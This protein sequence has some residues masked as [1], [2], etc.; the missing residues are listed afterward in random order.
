MEQ[1]FD[2]DSKDRSIATVELRWLRL[3][4]RLG[5]FESF[6]NIVVRLLGLWILENRESTESRREKLFQGGNDSRMIIEDWSSAT[7]INAE[8]Y[9]RKDEQGLIYW[10]NA[11]SPSGTHLWYLLE[12]IPVESGVRAI[13]AAA[14]IT[15]LCTYTCRC[16]G[17]MRV[18][19]L[20]ERAVSIGIRPFN[21]VPCVRS[22]PFFSSTEIA[23][24]IFFRCWISI[25]LGGT[26]II[27]R[28]LAIG[29]E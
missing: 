17:P 21:P 20:D 19:L 15:T 11:V 16:A 22:I 23:S 7:R 25:N 14:I 18:S 12:S 8:K 27:N 6:E 5:R 13:Q 9:R 10:E 29:N 26:I 2:K 1:R 3:S 24:I 4:G 28:R